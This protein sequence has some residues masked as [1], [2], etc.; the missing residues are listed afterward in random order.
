MIYANKLF[1]VQFANDGV[2][3]SPCG[4]TFGSTMSKGM[5]QKCS[6]LF[7]LWLLEFPKNK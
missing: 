5:V 7:K 6:S 3:F 1:Q 2:C 4:A